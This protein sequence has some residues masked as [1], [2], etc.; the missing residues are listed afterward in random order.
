MYDVYSVSEEVIAW[1]GDESEDSEAALGLV[2]VLAPHIKSFVELKTPIT[3]DTLTQVDG[4]QYPSTKWKALARLLD[5]PFFRQIWIIQELVVASNVIFICGRSRISWT[6][7]ASMINF[8]IDNGLHRL[9]SSIYGDQM[10]VA[11]GAVGLCVTMAIQLLIQD[12]KKL[13]LEWNLLT[14]HDFDVTNA[15]DR[16]FALLN[17]SSDAGDDVLAPDY[18]KSVESVLIDSTIHLLKKRGASICILS[19]AGIGSRRILGELPSWVLDWTTIPTTTIFGALANNANLVGVRS[20]KACGVNLQEKSVVCNPHL[21][22]I[23]L[24]AEIFDVVKS[25]ANLQPPLIFHSDR[26][27]RRE[28]HAAFSK[29]LTEVS[30]LLPSDQPY[31]SG[32]L[33]FPDVLAST[34]IA[35]LNINYNLVGEVAI[36]HFLNFYA[37]QYII[38]ENEGLQGDTPPL[39]IERAESVRPQVEELLRTLICDDGNLLSP[40]EMLARLGDPPSVSKP[41]YEPTTMYFSLMSSA[42]LASTGEVEGLRRVYT[43]RDGYIGLGPYLTQEDDLICFIYGT[44]EPFIIHRRSDGG[45]FLVGESYVMA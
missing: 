41:I 42:I 34:L 35:D 18:S 39:V 24:K 8:I 3:M 21:R 10:T 7:L 15:R 4:C 22:S 31:P 44:Y 30:E 23:K 28:A 36:T 17:I 13:A 45:Y 29:W 9:V 43:T 2:M 19:A 26:S 14:S 12:G 33:F 11:I 25:I 5:R 16:V 1:A 6:D 38:A 27:S 37:F 40:N 32:E 20:F